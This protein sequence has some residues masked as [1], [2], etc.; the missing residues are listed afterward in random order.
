MT[1]A[2]TWTIPLAA[3][4]IITQDSSVEE[5]INVYTA[6]M[7]TPAE[8]EVVLTNSI[9]VTDIADPFPI[10][11]TFTVSIIDC[12][13]DSFAAPTSPSD[14]VEYTVGGST[15]A[16]L[17]IP[18]WTQTDG[19]V[20]CSYTE[21]LS[22]DPAL[23]G[24]STWLSITDRTITINE[25]ESSSIPTASVTITVTSSLTNHPSDPVASS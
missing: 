23:E 2:F 13:V 4:S 10:A 25:H 18:A 11:T 24:Y 20:V 15:I 17:T 12:Q 3:A 7:G 22:F 1:E 19:A 6:V 16:V 14:A 21:L 5:K 8:Y 9:T